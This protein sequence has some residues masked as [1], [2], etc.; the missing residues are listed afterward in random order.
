M[1]RAGQTRDGCG[2]GQRVFQGSSISNPN[3]NNSLNGT[4]RRPS[5]AGKSTCASGATNSARTCRQAPHGGLG[6]AL[7]L[8]TA[9]ASTRRFEPNWE[10]ADHGRPLGADGEAKACVFYVSS[11][12]NLAVAEF[13]GGPDAEAGVGRIGVPGRM[14][15]HFVK[16]LQGLREGGSFDGLGHG[17]HLSGSIMPPGRE[18]PW[19]AQVRSNLTDIDH[20]RLPQPVR[21]PGCP[22]SGC[23]G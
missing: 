17:L 4:R 20:R 1:K 10:M 19:T 13:E 8:A 5:A 9:T 12:G 2:D 3:G 7:R 22:M 21:G 14:E 6:L 11:S 23:D 16:L 15:G 18:F